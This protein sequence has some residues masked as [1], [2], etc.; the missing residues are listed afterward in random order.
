[1]ENEMIE[2]VTDQLIRA[3]GELDET[4]VIICVKT[5]LENGVDRFCIQSLLNEGMKRVGALY[6]TGE[7]F[8][9]DLIVSGMIYKNVLE[10]PRMRYVP[11]LGERVAGRILVGTAE[12]DVHDIG[13][14]LLKSVLSANGFDVYDLG[15]DVPPKTFVSESTRLQ[16]DIIAISGVM[17]VAVSAMARTIQAL[18]DANLRDRVK[19]I[20]GGMCMSEE[21][22]REIGAD[23]YS[24]D[25]LEGVAVCKNFLLKTS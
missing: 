20:V 11:K 19:V 25:P 12:G 15:T 21:L 18:S 14:D 24:P 7:Y 5:L 8:I 3:L 17:T 22:S 16:P 2:K 10:L 23:A 13:K 9:A 1:M 4:Q 6:E